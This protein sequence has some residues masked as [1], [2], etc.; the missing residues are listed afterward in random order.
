MVSQP[1]P[2][3]GNGSCRPGSASS[4]TDISSQKVA[5]RQ[6]PTD[7][8]YEEDGLF[9]LD[10]EGR[11]EKQQCAVAASNILRNFSFMPDNEVIMAQHRHCLET[12]FQCIEDQN[13]GEFSFYRDMLFLKI[14]SPFFFL[15]G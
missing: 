10:E 7:W 11:A 4:V 5:A 3:R 8:W 9:N 2:E 14:Q 12:I 6:R 13:T 15:I 1:L